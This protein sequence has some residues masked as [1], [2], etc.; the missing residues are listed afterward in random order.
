MLWCCI[1]SLQ[2]RAKAKESKDKDICKINDSIGNVAVVVH[3]TGDSEEHCRTSGQCNWGVRASR[4]GS[5]AH[6]LMD[7][8]M[9]AVKC[10]MRLQ[11]ACGVWCSIAAVLRSR[12]YHNLL[13]S[14]EQCAVCSHP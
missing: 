9:G 13:E 6:V 7:G 10:R 3:T 8:L 11:R 4:S 5:K 12:D 14:R 1:L 2:K